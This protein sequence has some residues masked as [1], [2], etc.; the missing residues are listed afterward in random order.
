MSWLERFVPP[1][2]WTRRVDIRLGLTLAGIYAPLVAV[3]LFA[4]YAFA[5]SE[6]LE[7]AEREVNERLSQ[8][9][10]ALQETDPSHRAIELDLLREQLARDAGGFVVRNAAGEIV[11]SGGTSVPEEQGTLQPAALLRAIRTTR[12]DSLKAQIHVSPEATLEIHLGSDGFVQERDEIQR[13]FWITLFLGIALVAAASVPATRRALAPL[14]RATHTAEAMD[15]SRLNSRLPSRGTNDDVDRHSAAVNWLLDRIESGFA[16]I[17]SFSQDVAHE[18]RTPVN[19]ILNITEIA[20]LEPT[21]SNHERGELQSIRDSAEQMARI[22]DNLLLLARGDEGRLAAKNEPVEIA[23]LCDTLREMYEPA[24]EEL[25][26]DLEVAVEHA[27]VLG[28]PALLL[29]TLAN[30]VDNAMAH[31]PPGGSI[32][33]TAALERCPRGWVEIETTDT[34]PGIPA[35]DRERIFDR[36]V[37]LQTA[38]RQDGGVGLGLAIARALARA[39]GGDVELRDTAGPGACFVIRLPIADCA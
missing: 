12:D 4:L 21:G 27:R 35:V 16:R 7:L 8:L 20:L 5:A 39:H 32:R 1:T 25:G 36:F 34:G 10:T 19:R 33:L 23:K 31:T 18:L 2:G 22:V 28:D 30:L 38:R 24:C 15:V 14:R 37:R 29:R 17:Q 6:L 26:I 13:G 9:Q 11:A 3:V